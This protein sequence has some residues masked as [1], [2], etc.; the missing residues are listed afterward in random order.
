MPRYS[1]SRLEAFENCPLRYK[2]QY[3]DGIEVEEEG[4]EAFMGSRVHETLEK[5]YR[6]LKLSRMNTLDDLYAYYREVWDKNW[7][8]KVI[9]NRKGYTIE[10]YLDTGK[11]CIERYYERFCPF[12][13]GTPVWI[14][15]KVF[16]NIA[17]FEMMGVVDR[18]DRMADGSF[19]IHDYKTGGRL[20]SQI[21]ADMDR[22]LALY[23]IAVMEKWPVL[24]N[25]KLVWHYLQFGQELE[26]RRTKQQL[27]DVRRRTAD[28]INRI[29]SI[30]VFEPKPNRLCD[31]CEFW[32][33]CPE[34][35]HIAK[36]DAMEP[37]DAKDDDG[38]ML[39]NA[40]AR[41]KAQ[42]DKLDSELE[43]LKVRLVDYAKREGLTRVRGS[44]K[45]ASVYLQTYLS[46]PTE[47]S[48]AESYGAIVDVVK[49]AGLW[50]SFA[51][52]NMKRLAAS[53]KSGDIEKKVADR[54][55]PY[56]EERETATVRLGKVR[57]EDE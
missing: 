54:L 49:R 17:D 31:W 36:I 11:K 19:E 44:T 45:V 16:F 50:D 56:A 21:D 1:Y 6:D 52:L 43:A 55:M 3:I 5:L 7:H 8:D 12:D 47:S 32:E 13:Q 42:K 33:Y 18:L 48:D 39:V 23:Q 53:L 51:A 9:I 34:K 41:L 46:L 10:N 24:K 25:I 35:K 30:D 2:L 26:S 57:D 15:E 4:I 40:Y 14:E 27:Q 37:S 28:I 22:Q 20:P 29:E 38:Y